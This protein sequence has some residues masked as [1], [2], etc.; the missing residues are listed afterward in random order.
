MPARISPSGFKSLEDTSMFKPWQLG[1]LKLDHKVVLAPLTRMRAVKESEGVWVPGDL[2]VEY[3]SQRASKGGLLLTEACPISRLACGYP[4]IPGI[5]TQSQIS[6]WKRVTDAVHAKGGFIYCQLWHVG[7]ATVPSLS[8]R[9]KR[10]FLSSVL[11]PRGSRPRWCR[12]PQLLHESVNNRT[13]DY[14]GSVENRC[15]FIPE[16]IKAVTSAIGGDKGGIRLSPYNYFQ[17]T[18]DFDPNKHWEFLC[19]Q[20]ADLP[21]QQQ[22]SYIHMIEPRFDGVL[23]EQAK[24]ASLK[25]TKATNKAA[26]TGYCLAPFRDLLARAD[27]N[28]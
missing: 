21:K 22:L 18:R 28:F 6:G 2:N 7:R 20:I 13:D 17:D 19:Q 8:R 11:P 26:G 27:I 1:H 4:G 5:F 14:G 12:S 23:D 15:R 10:L 9:F 24:I 3:Y 16:V 25:G